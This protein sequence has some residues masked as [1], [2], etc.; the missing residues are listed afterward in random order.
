MKTLTISLAA[1]LMTIAAPA[2]AAPIVSLPGGTAVTLGAEQRGNGPMTVAPGII[3]TATDK[4]VAGYSDRWSFDRNG[5]WSGTPMLGLNAQT[6]SFTITFDNAVAGFLAEINWASDL[7]DDAS[8][9]AFDAA[10]NAIESIALTEHTFD[11]VEPGYLGFGA[12]AAPIK[13][14]S[15]TNSFIGIRN[16]SISAAA[17]PEPATWA[18]M[19]IGFGM[20]AASLRYRRAGTKVSFA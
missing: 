11:L 4:G 3:L 9:T 17:V 14:I 18:M 5:E 6:G 12:T 10:G 8:M 15:F 16:L 2:Y 1:V 19:L 7:Y 13:S 20:M